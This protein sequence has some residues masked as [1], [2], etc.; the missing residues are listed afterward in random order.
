MRPRIFSRNGES[1]PSKVLSTSEDAVE[2]WK[3]ATIG[4]VAMARA[5]IDVLGAFGSW[6]CSTSGSMS[7]IH[8][9][10]ARHVG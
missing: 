10:V 5:N 7:A 9:F 2:V 8:L 6:M 4:P 1:T 3:V